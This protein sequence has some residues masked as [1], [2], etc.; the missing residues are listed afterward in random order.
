MSPWFPSL[1]AINAESFRQAAESDPA[2]VILL[3][4]IW[5]PTSRSLDTWLREA[6][7]DYTNLRFYAMD[8]DQ[9][10]NWP[11]AREWHIMTTPSLVCLRNGSFHE[12]LVGRRPEPQMRAKLSGW[13]S[14]GSDAQGDRTAKGNNAS[15]A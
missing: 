5:D 11:L 8:L 6:R 3:W 10:Q 2:A 4:A 1:P 15:R 12:L 9:E 13:N 14:L 7:E